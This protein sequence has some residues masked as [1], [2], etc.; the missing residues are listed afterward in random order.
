ML[1]IKKTE[2]I[3]IAHYL[4][5]RPLSNTAQEMRDGAARGHQGIYQKE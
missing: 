2:I 1:N 3:K 5:I 4:H